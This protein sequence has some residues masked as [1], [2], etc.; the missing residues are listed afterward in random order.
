MLI[1]LVWH[2]QVL[3]FMPSD[4]S[5]RS[6]FNVVR[7]VKLPTSGLVEGFAIE[8]KLQIVD[9]LGFAFPPQLIVH[10]F[11]QFYVS[12]LSPVWTDTLK[13]YRL[14]SIKS[15]PCLLVNLLQLELKLAI[16]RVVLLH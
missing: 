12:E 16:E 6:H 1:Q 8:V 9:H 14:E 11:V 2:S 3:S 5:G 13:L 4:G 10:R 7:K 15:G